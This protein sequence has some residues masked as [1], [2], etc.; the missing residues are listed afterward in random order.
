MFLFISTF[1]KQSIRSSP[2]LTAL[3][4]VII[5]P[6]CC[7]AKLPTRHN[8]DESGVTLYG[9]T[10]SALMSTSSFLGLVSRVLCRAVATPHF[11]NVAHIKRA[12]IV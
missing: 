11:R 1:P 8:T 4:A 5:A 6:L 9:N 2:Y 12:T 7:A 3:S 10:M